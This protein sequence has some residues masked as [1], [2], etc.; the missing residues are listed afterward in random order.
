MPAKRKCRLRFRISL[1]RIS[2]MSALNS[3]IGPLFIVALLLLY[4]PKVLTGTMTLG[5]I[6]LFVEY[7]SRL[8]RPIAEIAESLR[9]LQQARTSLSRIRKIMATPE[10]PN[11]GSGKLP[12][13]DHEIRFDHVWFAYEG[14]EWILRDLSFV[15]PK[16]SFSAIVG[17]SGSGKSTT[18]SLI[19]GFV[20]PQK[21]HVLIDGIPL[22]EIDIIAWRK[23]I[24]LVLQ[25]HSCFRFQYSKLQGFI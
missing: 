16:D 9:S 24:G 1:N 14:E 5:T 6:L 13:L 7:G 21:G 2:M 18:I 10:E 22:D 15:I 8:L 4:A 23:H 12:T 3:L 17:A 25:N 19:C 11:R 20:H